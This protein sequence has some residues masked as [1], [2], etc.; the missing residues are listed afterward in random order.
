MTI[1]IGVLCEEGAVLLCD[2]MTVRQTPGGAEGF[3][4]TE[5]KLG[6]LPELGL[7]FVHSGHGVQQTVAP[8]GDFA[9]N[10][11]ALHAAYAAI[12][13][14]VL[15]SRFVGN[16]REDPDPTELRRIGSQ[17]VIAASIP[18]GQLVRI[19]LDSER[20]AE[21]SRIF[22]AGAPTLWAKQQGIEKLDIPADLD[23]A[24]HLGVEI[25]SAFVAHHTAGRTMADYAAEGVIPP[26]AF[27]LHVI[28]IR[29]AG[30]VRWEIS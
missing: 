26:V 14:P 11:R 9:S 28:A 5:G 8:V 22:I 13:R 23:G 12:E 20:W 16:N 29:G 7:A 10:A 19:D 27:P 3:L 2:S 4:S 18:S 30:V 6:I 15:A 17:E 24:A 21:G 25:A 1:A